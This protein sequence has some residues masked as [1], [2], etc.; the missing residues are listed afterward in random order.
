METENNKEVK[1]VSTAQQVLMTKILKSSKLKDFEYR[2]FKEILDSKVTTSYDASVFIEY[3]LG[4]LKFRRHFFN[5]R[6]KA[7]KKCHY[8]K[9]R[10]N[11]QRM[12]HLESDSKFWVCKTCSINLD[13]SKFVPVKIAE[14]QEA[15]ADLY[16]KYDYPAE[17]EAIDEGLIHEKLQ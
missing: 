9:S 12:L 8:C 1:Q 16:R 5:G 7:Y 15:K 13:D 3:V 11:I 14:E 4:M 10:D 2:V 17:Q 6:H